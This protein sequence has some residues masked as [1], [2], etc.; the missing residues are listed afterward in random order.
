[1]HKIAFIIEKGLK[2]CKYK[3]FDYNGDICSYFTSTN[4]S[5]INSVVFACSDFAPK[6]AFK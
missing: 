1:M 3:D 5:K 6:N 4:I 2:I